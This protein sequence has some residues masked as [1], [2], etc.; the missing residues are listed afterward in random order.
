MAD[1]PRNKRSKKDT[2]Q[3]ENDPQELQRRIENQRQKKKLITMATAA[4]KEEL[5]RLKF[6]RIKGGQHRNDQEMDHGHRHDK[7]RERRH[8]SA[9]KHYKK[10]QVSV[11]DADSSDVNVTA[12]DESDESGSSSPPSSSDQS[13][14]DEK[15]QKRLLAKKSGKGAKPSELLVN[16]EIGGP[17]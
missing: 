14:E 5:D 6:M 4:T 10:R 16:R 2:P 1:K 3:E 11:A 17:K 7:K 15:E 12:S 9:D 8:S 13:D